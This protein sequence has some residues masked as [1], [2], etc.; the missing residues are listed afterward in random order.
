MIKIHRVHVALLYCLQPPCVVVFWVEERSHTRAEGGGRGWGRRWGLSHHRRAAYAQRSRHTAARD[1]PAEQL[2]HRVR[3]CLMLKRDLE[4][5]LNNSNAG[6]KRVVTVQ[7]QRW[8]PRSSRSL[9]AG[10][11]ASHSLISTGRAGY[12]R[13]LCLSDVASLSKCCCTCCST[14]LSRL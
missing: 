13:S 3:G 5:P 9:P 2:T 1:S 8:T 4:S 12:S 11:H 10:Q 7:Q 6:A 14:I